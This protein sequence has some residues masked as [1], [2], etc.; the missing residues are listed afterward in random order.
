LLSISFFYENGRKVSL[1]FSTLC[2]Y[3]R[4]ASSTCTK[5]GSNSGTSLTPHQ[6]LTLVVDYWHGKPSGRTQHQPLNISKG[7]GRVQQLLLT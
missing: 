1:S 2:L 5:S 7:A 6:T 3:A 4:T